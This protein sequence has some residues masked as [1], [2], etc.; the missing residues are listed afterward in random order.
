MSFSDQI[1][2]INGL[3]DPGS[4]GLEI[5]EGFH[6][7]EH[8]YFEVAGLDDDDYPVTTFACSAWGSGC[9]S[10][11]QMIATC[12]WHNGTHFD[13]EIFRGYFTPANGV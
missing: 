6:D 4:E 10:I 11:N 2:T 5:N 1:G 8:A 3:Y 12:V 7:C 13:T 9:P